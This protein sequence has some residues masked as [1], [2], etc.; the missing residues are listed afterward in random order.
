MLLIPIFI[1]LILLMSGLN[2]CHYLFIRY[3]NI[4]IVVNVFT[5]ISSSF[6]PRRSI[7]FSTFLTLAGT[8]ILTMSLFLVLT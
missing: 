7:A 4:I 2:I 5:F 8:L 6:P 3:V 1:F